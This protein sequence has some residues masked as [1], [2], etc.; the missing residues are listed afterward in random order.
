MMTPF[1]HSKKNNGISTLTDTESTEIIARAGEVVKY[2]TR[3]AAQAAIRPP[4]TDEEKPTATIVDANYPKLRGYKPQI[5]CNYKAA[6]SREARN[7]INEWLA[8]NEK[9]KTVSL[10]KTPVGFRNQNSK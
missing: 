4:P 3:A 2:L 1:D 10:E 7:I 8:R 9:T 5:V 6:G